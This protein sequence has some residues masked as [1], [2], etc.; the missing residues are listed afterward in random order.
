MILHLVRHPP[1]QVAAGVCY[2]R[3]DLP[4]LA[5]ETAAQRL[6]GLLPA[7]PLLSSPLCRCSALAE[8]L[9]PTPHYDSRWQEMDFGVWEGQAWEEIERSAL[10]AWAADVAGFAPPGG[11]S[12]RG[13]QRRALAAWEE[14]RAANAAAREA[15]LVT[16]AGVMRALLAHWLGWPESR[17]LE[18]RFDF[19]GVSSVALFPGEAPRLLRL[20]A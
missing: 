6:R 2:G 18:L 16:H 11:E 4:A 15:I 3:L 17:W 14:W 9:S 1:P 13:V 10:D 8:A 5:V 19:A 12:G 7:A 20:N